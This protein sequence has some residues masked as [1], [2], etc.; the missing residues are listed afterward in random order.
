MAMNAFRDGLNSTGMIAFV[1]S[2]DSM[3][4]STHSCLLA[5]LFDRLE[6][7]RRPPLPLAHGWLI[8]AVELS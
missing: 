5:L 2:N 7:R 1:L 6:A 8:V 4:L 3:I